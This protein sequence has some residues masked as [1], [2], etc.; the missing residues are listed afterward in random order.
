M[1]N[2]VINGSSLNNTYVYDDENVI[3]QGNYTLDAKQGNALQNISG[4]VYK[5]NQQ[6]EQG[7]YIG[8]FNGYV[9]EGGEIRYSISEMSRRNA[10][11]T[12]DAIDAIEAEITG[13]NAGEE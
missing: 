13:S 2:F 1:G 7:E 9:R 6:G 5:K 4:S 8:N 11:M 3:V 12:W 10:N